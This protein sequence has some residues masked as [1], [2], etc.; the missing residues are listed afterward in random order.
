MDQVIGSWAFIIGVLIAI[1][2]GIFAAAVAEYAGYITLVLV[3]LGLIV[4]FLNIGDK[5]VPGFLLAAVALMLVGSADLEVID[6]VVPPVGTYLSNI[7]TNIVVFVAPAA[8]VVA[9]LEVY[10]LASTPKGTTAK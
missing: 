6:T 8:L 2:G 1:F 10:R 3:I 5:E 4:G 7:V 9:L